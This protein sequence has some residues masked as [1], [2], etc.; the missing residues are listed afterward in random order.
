MLGRLLEKR[1]FTPTP[2]G[3]FDPKRIPSN[4]EAGSFSDAGESVNERTA[5]R[6][7]VVYA[8]VGILADSIAALP[9]DQF[10]R[11]SRTVREEV[12]AS[13]MVRELDYERVYQYVTSL[14]LRGNGYGIVTERDPLEFPVS[15]LPVHPDD[16]TVEPIRDGSV[17]PRR[18][19]WRYRVGGDLV[20]DED[21]IHLRRF[22]L[23]G[24][25][26]GLSPIEAAA[27][28]IGLGLA[29]DRFGARWFGDG[30]A[31]ASI[32]ST[33]Q[34]LDDTQVRRAQES[35]VNT[36]GGRRLPAVMSGGWEY[37]PVTITPNESQFLETRKFQRSEIA[38]LYRVPPHMIG[39]TEKSTSWGT[40]IEQQ[41]LGFVKFTLMPWLRCIETAISDQLPRGQF[42]RFNVDALLR[43]DLKSRYEAYT[44]ARNAGW[45]NVDEIRELEDREPVPDGRGQDYLQ[46]LN[47]GPLGSDPLAARQNQGD[48]DG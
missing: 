27:Q 7:I 9:I 28:A 40:G 24:L 37:K 13:R 47:M 4:G 26:V 43:G 25:P 21:V 30:A 18:R 31:P 44:H 12:P 23:P 17:D 10:R 1:A 34:D 35:W 2:G 41:S 5:L 14:A 38:M 15:V 3:A 6:L 11:R 16:V 32:L 8:C 22:V 20:P 39:D 33:E 19:G 42:V 36:H 48:N 29:A 46:P 45:L